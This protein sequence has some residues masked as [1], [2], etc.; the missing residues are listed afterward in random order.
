MSNSIDFS[1]VD[2]IGTIF[3]AGRPMVFINDQVCGFLVVEKIIRASYPEF[4]WA[5]IVYNSVG[6]E[7]DQMIAPEA[8]EDIVPMGS[9]VSICQH[10]NDGMGVT[11]L[12]RH[13]LF[14][15]Y[16][17]EIKTDI[18]ED[19]CEIR[20]KARDLSAKLERLKVCGR[21]IYSNGDAVFIGDDKT[22]FND[23]EEGNRSLEMIKCCGRTFYIFGGDASHSCRFSCSDAI[24]YLLC[25]HIMH[26]LVE[27]PGLPQIENVFG[28]TILSDIDVGG[29]K[30]VAAINKCCQQV[31][32]KFK[33]LPRQSEVGPDITIVFYRPGYGRCVEVNRQYDG[34]MF[35]V[36]RT[37]V[38]K[39]NSKRQSWPITQRYIGFGSVKEYEAT[40]ELVRA[41]DPAGEVYGQS[42]YS[43]TSNKFE[44]LKDVY[45][46]WCLN[47]GSDYSDLPF[48]AG[49]AFDLSNVFGTENYV[50]RRRRFLDCITSDV[51]GNSFGEYLEISYDSGFTWQE[52]AGSFDVL[53]DECGIWVSD[54]ALDNELWAAEQAGGLRF[55]VTAVIEGDERL[56]HSVADGPVNSSVEVEDNFVSL[57]GEYCFRKVT[58]QSILQKSDS[59]STG[60]PNEADDTEKLAAHLIRMANIT[61]NI[62]EQLEVTT[63]M[64]N[65]NFEPGDRVT[66]SPESRDILGVRRDGRSLFWIERVEMDFAK[67]CTKLEIVRQRNRIV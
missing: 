56:S 63:P 57:P 39:L 22:V 58:G 26:G 11:N 65:C 25:E 18:T 55:R 21:R 10:Y 47:E 45:R 46:K 61:S 62:A 13:V 53:T 41:W 64:V 15:G 35:S 27:L 51:E 49:D 29:M 40:F 34:D 3:P 31:G 24:Q 66:S 43:F 23:E 8:I 48:N 17:E 7:S 1:Q 67:Q 52:F 6:I 28:D 38:H 50:T 60:I 14:S 30:V 42:K 44:E 59:I 54:E 9:K 12:R 33:F 16:I 32:V 37:N 2:Q 20:L 36:S 5:E 19:G 4:G